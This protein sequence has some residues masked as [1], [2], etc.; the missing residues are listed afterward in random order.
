MRSY[1]I[2]SVQFSSFQF[3]RSVVSD[4]LRP[5]ESQHA[6]PPC[7]SPTPGVHSDS[8]PSSQWC[9][10]LVAKRWPSFAIPWTIACQ[11]S[12]S[13]GFSRWEY[14]SGLPFP[15]SG[16]LPNPRDW[17]RIC[18][19]GSQMLYHWATREALFP[20]GCLQTLVQYLRPSSSNMIPEASHELRL[21]HFYLDFTSVWFVLESIRIPNLLCCSPL[22]DRN[23]VVRSQLIIK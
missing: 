20:R 19:V 11:A 6:R 16:D 15:S 4:S 18:C 23:L 10:Y 2:S 21:H 9:C 17:T 13:V 8:C 14:W 7:P 5:H 3:S 12:L 1:W 22:M